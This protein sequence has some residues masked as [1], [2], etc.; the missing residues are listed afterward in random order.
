MVAD[1]P[2]FILGAG[3]AGIVGLSV[4][5]LRG[6]I[7]ILDAL[8]VADLSRAASSEHWPITRIWL[9]VAAAVPVVCAA[10]RL[11]AGA[12]L[13]GIATAALGYRVAPEFL[14]AA[15]RRVEEEILDDLAV[16]FDLIA[17]AME[18]RHSLPAAL[19]ICAERA[20]PGALKRA[21]N[22]VILEIHHG[23]DPLESLR[24]LEQRTGLKALGSLVMALRSAERLHLDA[25]QV[26]RERARQAAGQRFAQAERLARAAPLK[27][28]AALVLAIAPCTFVVLAFPIAHALAMIAG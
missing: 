13:A 9:G 24:G 11:G 14:A 25:A 10:S 17:L 18:A 21:W 28:W 26:F 27:L 7:D 2:W 5:A 15:R 19:A 8:R 12:W 23:A 4:F 20:P 1:L 22:R 6:L 16:H 3:L